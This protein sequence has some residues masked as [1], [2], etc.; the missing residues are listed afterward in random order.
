MACVEKVTPKAEGI[1]DVVP[2]HGNHF[3]GTY[4]LAMTV[5]DNEIRSTY[6]NITNPDGEKQDD[7]VSVSTR[8]APDGE[9]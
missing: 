8:V 9:E 2:V 5:T 3:L 4:T 7:L 1:F 6:S